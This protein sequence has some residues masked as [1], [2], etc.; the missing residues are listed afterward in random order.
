MKM[1]TRFYMSFFLGGF[2]LALTGCVSYEN[3]YAELVPVKKH[4]F[5]QELNMS[6]ILRLDR[7]IALS[8]TN[9]AIIKTP[10]RL[11]FTKDRIFVVDQG[12]NKVLMF[13]DK[14][15]FISSTARLIGKGHNE[16]IHVMDATLDVGSN[17]LYMHCDR[18]CQ[19]MV[20]DLN[21][22]LKEVVPMDYYLGSANL[23]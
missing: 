5:D 8:D 9:E 1:F 12:G 15:N 20:F 10:N 19:M 2:G 23:L 22:N 6:T 13:D 21:L 7:I 16:Y 11:L 17:R 14:G 4:G 3:S 18:P